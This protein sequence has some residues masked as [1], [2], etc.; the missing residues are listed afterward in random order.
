MK[1]P[2]NLKEW[3]Q[4]LM[5]ALE[6]ARCAPM[7]DADRDA[8]VAFVVKEAERIY[9]GPSPVSDVIPK[10]PPASSQQLEREDAFSDI[11]YERRERD[12]EDDD[13]DRFPF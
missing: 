8:L 13:P 11:G 5:G 4:F 2:A 10:T 3:K 9:Y 1:T 6:E 7:T 12:H